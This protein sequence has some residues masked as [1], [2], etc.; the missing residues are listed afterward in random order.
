MTVGCQRHPSLSIESDAADDYDA[1]ANEHTGMNLSGNIGT[2]TVGFGGGIAN[3]VVGAAS[4]FYVG[5]ARA[6]NVVNAINHSVRTFGS[7]TF[8][9]AVHGGLNGSGNGAV[10]G[11]VNGVVNGVRAEVADA[12][13]RVADAMRISPHSVQPR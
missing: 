4:S 11:A 3:N 2:N 8:A 12:R 1:A 9:S 5:A 13:A 6:S 7:H 10:N